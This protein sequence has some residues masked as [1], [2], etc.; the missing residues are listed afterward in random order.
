[1]NEGTLCSLEHYNMRNVFFFK[2]HI[3]VLEG[4]MTQTT[5]TISTESPYSRIVS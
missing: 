4:Y 5:Y 1:M 2:C 3:T